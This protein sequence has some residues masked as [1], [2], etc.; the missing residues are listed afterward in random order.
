MSGAG[1]ILRCSMQVP[2]LAYY[3]G[4]YYPHLT[5]TAGLDLLNSNSDKYTID[6]HS[7]LRIGNVKIPLT[8]SGEVVLNWYGQSLRTYRNIPFHKLLK[9]IENDNSIEKYDFKDITTCLVVTFF[10][11][12]SQNKYIY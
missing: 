10:Y 2:V 8:T 6:K 5:L 12:H 11:K 3:N 9:S 1:N 4:E 7:N